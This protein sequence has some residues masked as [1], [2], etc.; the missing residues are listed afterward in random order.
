[1][2]SFGRWV[3][4]MAV[5]SDRSSAARTFFE[6]FLLDEELDD[7][8]LKPGG[9]PDGFLFLGGFKKGAILTRIWRTGRD[10]NPR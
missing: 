3:S 2:E 9:L 1:M 10:S 5:R 6:K 4:I 8:A 7:F